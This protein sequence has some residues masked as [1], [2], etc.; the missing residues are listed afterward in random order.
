MTNEQGPVT[1]VIPGDLHLTEAGQPNLD[2]ALVAM[3]EINGLIRPDFVQFIGDNVQEGTAKQFEL[4]QDL[5]ASLT[6]PWFALVGDHDAMGDAAAT[7]FKAYLGDSIGSHSVSGF[8]F[9][10][11]N[12]QEGQPVGLSSGQVA[13]L[14]REVDFAQASGERVVLFQHNYPYQIWEDFAGP[15]IDDWREIVQTRRIHAIICGHTH[16]WQQ[17]NDGRNV[18]VATRS[19]GDPEGGPPGYTIAHFDREDFT[20]RF[21]SANEHGP[22]ALIVHPRDAL[23]ATGPTQVVKGPDE[24]RVRVWSR[25]PVQTA[26]FTVDGGSSQMLELLGHG[27]WKAALNGTRLKKGTHRLAVQIE[28]GG[29]TDETTIDFAVDATGRYTAVPAVRPIVTATNFC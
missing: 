23:L 21:R 3:E 26:R 13:W 18:Y 15:G 4:F 17:A 28:A 22:V 10:R 16:Y 19:I 7:R 8:R 9:I 12:T 27:Y 2:A 5:A 24:I 29:L 14:R 25:A 20:V 11:L 1:V 6:V